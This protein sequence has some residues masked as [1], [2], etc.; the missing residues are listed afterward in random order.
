MAVPRDIHSHYRHNLREVDHAFCLVADN[1]T[2][3]LFALAQ[4][5]HPAQPNENISITKQALF[6][7]FFTNGLSVL[8]GLEYSFWIIYLKIVVN[9]YV[10][11]SRKLNKVGIVCLHKASL[12]N[13]EMRQQK[14]TVLW[15]RDIMILTWYHDRKCLQAHHRPAYFRF[16]YFSLSGDS[17]NIHVLVAYLWY[18][19][20]TFKCSYY[21]QHL[22]RTALSY[23]LLI[24]EV[25][26]L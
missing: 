25:S 7:K 9:I 18:L 11:P 4:F 20:L 23:T 1:G 3:K 5:R 19:L 14:M 8:L 17:L 12:K 21:Y 15:F 24:Q 2:N 16:E 6:L 10:W 22:G 26:G 13:T